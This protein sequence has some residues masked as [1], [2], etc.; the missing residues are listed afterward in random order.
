MKFIERYRVFFVFC[1]HLCLITAAT[2]LAFLLRFE[3]NLRR[4]VSYGPTILTALPLILLVRLSVFHLLGVHRESWRHASINTLLNIV[5]AVSLSSVILVGVI[6]MTG[7]NAYPLSVHLIEW[8]VLIILMGG[9]R[10]QLRVAKELI[11]L[12]ANGGKRVL[13]MGAGTAGEMILREIK[14]NPELVYRAIG[15]IDDDPKKR[16]MKIHGVPVLGTRKE[17]LP[18]AKQYAVEEIVITIAS[19]TVRQMQEIVADCKK[20]GLPL[21]IVPGIGKMLSGNLSVSQIR[22]VALEDLLYRDV[23]KIDT[24]NITANL[25]DKRILVTGA[26]GSIGLEICRQISRCSPKGVILFDQSESSLY[27]ADLELR[28]AYPTVSF[29]PIIGDICDAHRVNKVLEQWQPQVLFHAAAY[30]HVPLMEQ[31]PSEAVKNNIIATRNLALAAKNFFVEKFVFIST[32]KAVNP[33]SV[34]GATKRVA[35]LFIRELSNL[36]QKT[37]FVT[38]RFGN[39]LGSDGSIIPLFKKQLE[40]G[41]PL[42][43]THPEV[44]RYFMLIPE[45]VQLVLQAAVMGTGG[46]IFVLDMG[47]QI[48][49]VDV[50]QSMIRLSGKDLDREIKIVFTGL[51]PGEKLYEELFDA[52]ESVEATDHE[53]IMKAMNGHGVGLDLLNEQ[54]A[55]MERLAIAG[56]CN[57]ILEKLNAMVSSTA[58]PL[59]RGSE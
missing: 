33:T 32:D 27:F 39:V 55:E 5:K 31:N 52:F 40:K 21:K 10:F 47:E 23:V 54:I 18:V 42:T 26:A 41:G 50:A 13:L 9:A 1:A 51:R 17:L 19:A 48:K 46:E 6:P 14:Q 4:P 36:D 16:G 25:K 37:C 56:E 43:V 45:A 3:F 12:R 22:D 15:F 28:A 29:I 24:E 8:F 35:E 44:K 11:V 20:S 57:A 38:V 58:V 7:L 59:G 34:M 49:I 30:K 2:L 53:K